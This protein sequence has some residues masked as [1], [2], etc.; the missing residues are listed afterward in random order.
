MSLRYTSLIAA[1]AMTLIA[2]QASAH[3]KLVTSNPAADATIAAPSTIILTFNETLVP[4]FTSFELAKASGGAVKVKTT[5]AAD[6]KTVTGVPA[7]KLSPGVYKVSWHAAASGD[8]HRM[9]GFFNF[10]VK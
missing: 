1:A 10:T 7:G 6:K 3:A 2:G 5:V 8:G 9:E 4:A